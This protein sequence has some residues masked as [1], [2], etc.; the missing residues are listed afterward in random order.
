MRLRC[1]SHVWII[2]SHTSNVGRRIFCIPALTRPDLTQ[3]LS[4]QLLAA[5]Y[6]HR[7]AQ[8]EGRGAVTRRGW[9]PACCAGRPVAAR[10]PRAVPAGRAPQRRVRSRPARRRRWR[11]RPGDVELGNGVEPGGVEQPLVVA[12]HG[13]RP[14]PGGPGPPASRRRQPRR[15]NDGEEAAASAG[16]QKPFAGSQH[17][18]LGAQSTQ[19][20]GVDDGVEAAG[21]EGESAGRGGHD[22]YAGGEPF[23]RGAVGGHA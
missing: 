8:G 23:G 22:A 15:F 4:C 14:G 20:V 19:H 2:G 16:P 11:R 9:R 13:H 6:V 5:G 17:G 12:A 7:S 21:S 3:V 18:E 10:K 1:H